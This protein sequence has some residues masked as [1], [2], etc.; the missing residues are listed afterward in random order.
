MDYKTSIFKDKKFIIVP[1]LRDL[2]LKH[3]FT[4]SDIN[5]RYGSSDRLNGSPGQSP[6][7]LEGNAKRNF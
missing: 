2:G 6:L 5:L 7:W 3:C 4:T 1:R